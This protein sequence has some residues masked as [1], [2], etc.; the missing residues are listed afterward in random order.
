MSTNLVLSDILMMI[1]TII[2]LVTLFLIGLQI[3]DNRRSVDLNTKAVQIS[4]YQDVLDKMSR[5]REKLSSSPVLSEKLVVGDFAEY[6]AGYNPTEYF[7]VRDLFSLYENVFLLHK[8][9]FV[10]ED[11]WLA[12][13]NN[14]ASDMEVDLFHGIWSKTLRTQ[15]SYEPEFSR[16]ID[17]LMKG[18]L[19]ES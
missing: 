16:Y 13:E 1:Q 17:S 12:W 18:R 10:E 3:R 9:G 7:I 5:L 4:I 2:Y 8:R 15:C 6:L 14:I 19:K 11:L